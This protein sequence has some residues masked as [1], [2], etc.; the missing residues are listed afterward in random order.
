MNPALPHLL[1]VEIG[2]TKLQ[3]GLGLGDG[4]IAVLRRLAVDPA[5]GAAGIRGQIAATVAELVREVGPIRAAGVGFGGPVSADRQSTVKSHQIGGWD[6][7]PLAAWIREELG[8]ARVNIHNDAD[9]AALGET[10][11][12][13]GAGKSPVLYVTIGSGI[14]GGLVVDGRIYRGNGAGAVEI[15]HLRVDDEGTK[16]LEDVAS[17]WGIAREAGRWLADRQRAGDPAVGGLLARCGGDPGRA[18]AVILA[19]AAAEGDPAARAFLDV[20][21]R[22]FAA[23]LAHAATL[24]APARIILGG[25]VA[26]IGEE[27]W[28]DPVRREL[29]RRVFG[30][31]RGTFDVV[32][33]ALGEEVVVHGALALAAE[34]A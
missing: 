10:R 20:T 1:G 27:F 22:R 34:V 31:L 11:F 30:P 19:A 23:G 24:L 3:L 9:T 26:L 18:T 5:R 33:A 29:D 21:T 2:G 4:T 7:F 6:A 28:F 25:G 12:G 13:A 8:V 16:T 17:G 14:G 32:P 15:G